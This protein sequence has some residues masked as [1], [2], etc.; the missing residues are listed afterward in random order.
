LPIPLYSIWRHHTNWRLAT[1]QRMEMGDQ[2]D[3]HY[4]LT[5]SCSEKDAHRIRESLLSHLK[6]VSQIIDTSKEE[7]IFVYCFDFFKWK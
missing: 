7:D 5:F 3:L 1:I 6:L 2:S 4:S